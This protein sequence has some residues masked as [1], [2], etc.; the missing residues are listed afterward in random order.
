MFLVLQGGDPE[1]K[2]KFLIEESVLE[3]SN[4][5]AADKFLLNIIGAYLL[6]LKLKRKIVRVSAFTQ[7]NE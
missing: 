7:R 3:L 2:Q 6:D 4:L 5:T 1:P